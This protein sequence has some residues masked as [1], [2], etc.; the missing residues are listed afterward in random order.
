MHIL[1]SINCPNTLA[2]WHF[3]ISFPPFVFFDITCKSNSIVLFHLNSPLTVWKYTHTHIHTHTRWKASCQVGGINR[4]LGQRPQHKQNYL[5][6]LKKHH[7]VSVL[8]W[9]THRRHG[10]KKVEEGGDT[11]FM[12]CPICH[13]TPKHSW[14]NRFGLTYDSQICAFVVFFFSPIFFDCFGVQT[15][16]VMI[17]SIIMTFSFLGDHRRQPK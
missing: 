1:N 8:V 13:S 5:E 17:W 7:I 4:R 15:W 6:P 3:C 2:N 11:V 12:A 14:Y 10:A 16:Y 9:T